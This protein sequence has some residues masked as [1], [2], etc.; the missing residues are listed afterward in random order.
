MSSTNAAIHELRRVMDIDSWHKKASF[1]YDT[2]RSAPDMSF[3]E[4]GNAGSKPSYQWYTKIG[5]ACQNF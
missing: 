1:P 5:V 3:D 2:M 4:H